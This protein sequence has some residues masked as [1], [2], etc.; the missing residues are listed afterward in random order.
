MVVVTNGI[1]TFTVS[2]GAAKIYRDMGFS[3]VDVVEKPIEEVVVEEVVD[4]DTLF[5]NEI[6]EKPVS[7]WT[8]DEIKRFA[9]INDIDIDGVRTVREAREMIKKFIS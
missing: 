2:S 6:K 5:V 8:K 1:E 9:N 7:Q 4:E 3:V